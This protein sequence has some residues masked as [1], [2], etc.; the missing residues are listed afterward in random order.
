MCWELKYKHLDGFWINF[1]DFISLIYKEYWFREVWSI[2]FRQWLPE[3]CC[4]GTFLWNFLLFELKNPNFCLNI[5]VWQINLQRLIAI[6]RNSN[7]IRNKL[8][9]HSIVWSAGSYREYFSLCYNYF[10]LVCWPLQ[11]NFDGCRGL[12][13]SDA[14][15]SSERFRDLRKR[16]G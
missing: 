6:G 14:G 3:T 16:P 4:L 7:F 10:R 12:T 5:N 2:E 1:I 13:L 9:E 8:K 11:L 15:D